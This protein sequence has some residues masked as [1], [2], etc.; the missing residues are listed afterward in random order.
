MHS[1]HLEVRVTSGLINT[2]PG[3]EFNYLSSA[4][5]FRTVEGMAQYMRRAARGGAGGAH[6]P[7]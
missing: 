2:R 5:A 3:I 6:F 7:S 4:S 1:L